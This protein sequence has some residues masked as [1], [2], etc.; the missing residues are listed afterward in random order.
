MANS[1]RHEHRYQAG[2][3]KKEGLLPA[4]EGMAHRLDEAGLVRRFWVSFGLSVPVVILSWF[5]LFG[6]SLETRSILGLFLSTIIFFYGGGIFIRGSVEELKDRKP[7]MMVL[8]AIAII[9]AYAYSAFTVLSGRRGEMLWEL[10]TLITIMLFGLFLEEK[11]VNKASGA[12]KEMA[13][14]LPDEA[15]IIKPGRSEIVPVEELKKGDIVRIRPGGRIPADAKVIRGESEVDEAMVTGESR[16]VRKNPDDEIIAGTI[17]QTGFLEAEVERI[18]SDTFL[19]GIMRLVAEAEASK[20]KLQLVSDRAAFYL[21]IIAVFGAAG[22][23]LF[24]IF[25][26]DDWGFAM[27]RAISLLVVACPHALGLAV[28]LIA[29]ISVTLSVENGFFIRRREALEEARNINIVVFDKTG[30]L[31]EGSYEISKIVVDNDF[32]GEE[33]DLLRL[34]G[35][36]SEYS[37]HF[38]SKAVVKKARE[39]EMTFS[40][41][42][43]FKNIPGRGIK[44]IVEKKEI[45]IGGHGII[46]DEENINKADR[47]AGILPAVGTV[48]FVIVD[49]KLAGA[50]G[51][52]DEIKKESFVGIEELGQMGIETVMLTG[53][54]R[55]EAVYVAETLGIKKYFYGIKP[56]EKAEKIKELRREGKKVMMVGDGIND[57]PALAAADV[58]VAVGAG[59]NVAISSAGIIL[60][61]NDPRDIPAILKLSSV[62]YRKMM[63]NLFWATGYNVF[64]LPLAGGVLASYGILLIPAMSAILMTVSTLIVAVNALS[65]RRAFGGKRR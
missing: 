30:T 57:A 25:T 40:A 59:T 33:N 50:I 60:V 7:G 53:D 39:R 34:A 20:S 65:L 19:S 1:V 15:E 29:S 46:E 48:N 38:A 12:L 31:T 23:F 58:G 43:D 52:S 24:W 44:G 2:A 42:A 55:E 51:F 35:S 6:F 62:S 11:A 4:K 14:L 22:T 27:E 56:E 17:N 63:E 45:M 18:G 3:G 26:A 32:S 8:I 10:A 64:A 28:P 9:A 21:T 13:K 36:L 5:G 16:P 47:L 54:R 37:E 61:R 41:V 49:G